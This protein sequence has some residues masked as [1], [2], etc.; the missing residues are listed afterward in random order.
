MLKTVSP[1]EYAISWST[2]N[3][4][5]HCQLWEHNKC[6][7]FCVSWCKNDL[8]LLCWK[9]GKKTRRS[10]C[11]VTPSGWWSHG[12]TNYV[13]V[14]YCVIYTFEISIKRDYQFAM[15]IAVFLSYSYWLIYLLI[16]FWDRFLPDTFYTWHQLQ[17]PV[18]RNL[19]QITLSC[20]EGKIWG[21]VRVFMYSQW[22]FCAFVTPTAAVINPE[23][24]LFRRSQT[25]VKNKLKFRNVGSLFQK[26]TFANAQ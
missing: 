12:V 22:H 10:W 16:S 3:Y 20:F 6:A 2:W 1:H 7:F 19:K 21:K 17:C 14:W 11:N 8:I 13:S 4:T 25:G 9:K 23:V 24:G 5:K 18:F 15:N 26:L